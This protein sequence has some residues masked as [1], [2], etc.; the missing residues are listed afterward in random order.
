MLNKEWRENLVGIGPALGCNR[1]RRRDHRS[2]HLQYGRP[3]RA[4]GCLVEAR[5]FALAL[6]AVPPN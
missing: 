3:K 5:D 4:Q 1:H 2:G 6:P